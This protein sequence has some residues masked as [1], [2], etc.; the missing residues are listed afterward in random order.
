[1]GERRSGLAGRLRGWLV[2]AVTGLVVACGGGGGT[3]DPGPIGTALRLT[4][5]TSNPTVVTVFESDAPFGLLTVTADLEGDLARLNGQT[6]YVLVEDPDAWFEPS[7]AVQTTPSGRGNQLTLAGKATRGRIGRF[8]GSLRIRVC[9]DP[10]CAQPL[11]NSPLLVPY[12]LT[13]VAGPRFDLIS[14]LNVTVRASDEAPQPIALTFT[15]PAGTQS[16]EAYLG[17]QGGNPIGGVSLGRVGDELT[18]TFARVAAGTTVQ[19]IYLEAI[20][21]LAPGSGLQ[22]VR[23][24]SVTVN[25]IV[26]P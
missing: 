26:Q 17:P 14:P 11:G 23:G 19:A 9:V 15:L 18:L 25:Y 21:P 22:L 13:V 24:P 3:S 12:D 6:V 4:N 1:M 2:L 16:W 8:Q 7:V 5:V 20:A 10:A